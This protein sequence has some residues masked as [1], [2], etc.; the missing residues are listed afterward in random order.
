M[1]FNLIIPVALSIVMLLDNVPIT[2][3]LISFS[4]CFTFP[5]SVFGVDADYDKQE[6]TKETLQSFNSSVN[7][8][9]LSSTA[10]LDIP[11]DIYQLMLDAEQRYKSASNDGNIIE[12]D[13]SRHNATSEF[14]GILL[15]NTTLNCK[16]SI[17]DYINRE[18]PI[19]IDVSKPSV[20][21]Y[22]THSSETY[23][24]LDKGYYSNLRS[25]LSN[26]SY[27]NMIR[28]GEEICK[29][30]EKNGYKTI[31]D[32]TIY[33]EEYSGAYERSRAN[34]ARILKENPSIQVVLD[35]H[36][37]SIYQKDGSRIKTVTE[38]NSK[39]TAQIQ[40]LCG[41]E[42]GNVTNFPDWENNFT[43]ALNLQ[44]KIVNNNPTI[45][46]P[47]NLCSRKYNMDLM[48]CALQIEIGTDANTLLEAVY[49]AELF[50]ESLTALLKECE[51]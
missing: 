9:Q 3:K 36:R 26:N 4:F 12:V 41:C 42:D 32:K 46:R 15:R 24:L 49:S 45:V 11:S 30:L 23:E 13:Y 8:V 38:I 51:I 18:I 40:I 1:F 47:L 2:E 50:A 35:I 5:E 19:E 34:V 22:H 6:N 31:H 7:A 25:S 28:V 33:D 37:G 27:E 44:K 14:N 39:K 43:F 16:V 10:N 17:S 48:P 21:I 20:L 29:V